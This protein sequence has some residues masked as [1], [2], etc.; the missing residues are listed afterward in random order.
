MGVEESHMKTFRG[1]YS[2]QNW[3]KQRTCYKSPS[4][5]TCID[6][7][8]TNVPRGFQ[9]TC[10]IEVGLPDF[11]LMMLTVM[12]KSFKIF[13]PRIMRYRSYKHFS[14]DTFRKN[15]LS[16]EKFVINDDGLKRFCELS[17]IVLNKHAARNRKQAKGNQKS[18]F[19]KELSKEIKT[20]SRVRNK[21]L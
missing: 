14:N 16:N 17:V 10:V 12:K 13:Q 15:Q 7:V 2:L 9:S 21:Y 3:I 20:R 1:N 19:T 4:R 11:H 8:L 6:L 18:C 5:P